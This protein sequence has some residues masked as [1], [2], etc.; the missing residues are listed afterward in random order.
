MYHPIADEDLV[1]AALQLPPRQ[2]MFERAYRRSMATHLPE[3]AKI[4]WTFTLTP[5]TIS[6]M[7]VIAKKAAQLTLGK[8][9]RNTRLGNHPL[10]RQRHYY[11]NHTEWSRTV[12]KPFIEKTLLSPEMDALGVFN[13]QGLK[14]VIQ[15]HFDGHVTATHFLGAAL[16]LAL[17]SRLFFLPSVPVAPEA[18]QASTRQ[19]VEAQ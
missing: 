16:T 11:V 17:W 9:L 19:M 15:D 6:V 3:M 12:L 8:Y 2:L 4:P 10:I 7:G 1:M 14:Q 13:M 18:L 5:P